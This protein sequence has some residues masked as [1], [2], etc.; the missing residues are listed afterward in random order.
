MRYAPPAT[1]LG[2]A[3]YLAYFD[4]A[5]PSAGAALLKQE[6]AIGDAR[7]GFAVATAAALAYAVVATAAALIGGGPA[8]RWRERAM[9]IGM[10]L[11]TGGAAALAF[12]ATWRGFVAA[13]LAVG[14]GQALFVPGAAA[15]I[16]NMT[17]GERLARASARFTLASTAGRSS[18]VLIAGLIIAAIVGCGCAVPGLPAD[19]RA[20][21]LLT[22]LRNLAVIAMLARRRRAEPPAIADPTPEAPLR[23]SWPAFA[24][25]LAIA[26]APILLIHS[27]G[28][29]SPVLLVRSAG[30]AP[31]RAA[32][33]AGGVTLMCAMLGQW[34]GGR[35]LDRRGA[36][37]RKP[38]ATIAPAIAVAG[39]SIAMWGAAGTG[40]AIAALAVAD[41]ALGIATVASLTA[42]QAITPRH[43]R[44]RGNSLFFALVTL[45]GV[46]L[47]PLLTGAL[48]DEAGAD[49][50]ALA[51]G[52][53][54]VAAAALL[55]AG[56]GHL[57][58]RAAMR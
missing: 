36:R 22:A 6:L 54:W 49:A 50:G 17:G 43:A 46:G 13:E 39:A 41:F 51:H 3:V 7:L 24:G 28:V 30:L 11:W 1:V 32:M 37:R 45:V 8:Q 58:A 9:P 38:I 10:M 16:A 48:S 5:M 4:R 42:V 23:T 57:Q 33:V 19:W 40:P 44:H 26:V 18:A 35:W 29:W 20:L 55:L 52:I 27:I 25:C 34:L 15:R 53:G 14:A 56:A 2:I 47:G 21:F 31:A 12:A